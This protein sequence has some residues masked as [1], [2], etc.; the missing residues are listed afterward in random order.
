VTLCVND[1]SDVSRFY[2]QVVGL[3]RLSTAEGRTTLGVGDRALLDL[4]A[5]PDAPERG[6]AETGLFHTAFRFPDRA[7]LGDAFARVEAEWG[8]GLTGASDHHVSEALYL[9][10]PE[11]NGVELY[12]DRPRGMWPHDESGHVRM[13][14]LPLDLVPLREAAGG[15]RRAPDGT[16]VGHVHLEVSSLVEAERFYV[17]TLGLAVR[18]RFGADAL[19]LAIGDYHH[20][21]GV[22][23]WNGRSE[24]P[25]GRGLRSWELRL[26]SGVDAVHE[27][28]LEAG[29]DPALV[30]GGIEVRDPDGIRLRLRPTED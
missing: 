24:P 27:R 13:A 26:P 28:L 4:V 23:V 21:L 11:G 14:T 8:P 30:D 18:Q 19:F 22:N 25:A 9:D 1:P 16:T 17:D 29:S 20:H 2:R 7:A 3:E 6:P 10:D 12:T 15:E 5:D